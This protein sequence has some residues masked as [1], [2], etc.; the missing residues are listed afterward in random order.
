MFVAML[1]K[2][3]CARLQAC[4]CCYASQNSVCQ[5]TGMCLLLG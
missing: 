1:V 2:I 3:V 5:A 4:V